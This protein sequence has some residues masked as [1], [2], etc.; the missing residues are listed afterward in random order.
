M[1]WSAVGLRAAVPASASA[2]AGD[3]PRL[4]L[5]RLRA[6]LAVSGEGVGSR[7]LTALLAMPALEKKAA[8]RGEDE[9]RQQR[10][11]DEA[12]DDDGRQRLLYFRAD[13]M[14]DGHGNEADCRND[15][16][17]EDGAEFFQHPLM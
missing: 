17:H 14:S 16:R 9:E 7:H 4:Y 3:C 6:S 11:G 5:D 13:A 8:D 15:A 1:V 10:C 2:R 12:A